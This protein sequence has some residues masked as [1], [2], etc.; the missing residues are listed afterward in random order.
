MPLVLVLLLFS[1]IVVLRGDKTPSI[2][3]ASTAGQKAPPFQ[4]AWY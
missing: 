3:V 2:L 1:S 4:S